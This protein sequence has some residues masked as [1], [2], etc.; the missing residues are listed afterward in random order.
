MAADNHLSSGE[1][2]RRAVAHHQDGE[3][4]QARA[5]YESFLS[6]QPKH[7]GVLHLLGLIA[8]Q[9]G[10]QERAVSLMA[11][12]T[13]I[14]PGNPIF[15]YNL[16]LAL[17]Q[18]RRFEEALKNYDE[19][20]AINPNHAEAHSNRG[21]ALK[22]L[23]RFDE[24][25]ASF[26]VAL[27][28]KPALVEALRNRG[29]THLEMKRLPDAI[30]DFQAALALNPSMPWLFGQYLYAKMMVCDW[31]EFH[32]NRLKLA[33]G[34]AASENITIPFAVLG[35]IDDP[36]LQLAAAAAWTTAEIRK[37]TSRPTFATR[38]TPA[39]IRLG[40]YSADFRAHATSYLMAEML[41]SHDR[42]RFE[43]YA[44][45]FGSQV[46]DLMQRRVASAF[47]QFID[48]DRGGDAE[49]AELSRRL[50][51]DIAI[52]LKG[53][54]AD[55]RPG[56]F[57]ARCAPIQ[58]SFLGYPGTMGAEFIDYIVADRVVLPA[59]AQRY[60]IEKAVYLPGA[61]QPNDS[62]RAVS[63]RALTRSDVGLPEAGFVFCCFNN[64]YKITP[65]A[66]DIWMRVLKAVTGSVLWLLEDNPV[67]AANLRREADIRGISG[68]RLIFAQRLPL[69]EH[70][71]RQK[72]ADLFLDTF[73]CTAH[74]TASD[75]LWAGLPVLTLLGRSFAS[76]VAGSLNLAL[77]LS[78]LVVSSSG[79]YEARAIELASTRELGA[80]RQKLE[81][82]RASAA[83]FSGELFARRIEAAYEIMHR[84]HAASLPPEV[85]EIKQ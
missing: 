44:F 39:K 50:E 75:A 71:A 83:L 9:T 15:H 84:R 47:R 33:A 20:I 4:E 76:R 74:T 73:P 79:A 13:R 55:A 40:Y 51:I 80:L 32:D 11:E 21:A 52:D 72:L 24:A 30:A 25:L 57:A 22:D 5:L 49:V 38:K 65:E 43:L 70:L 34:I 14:Q 85:I 19:V 41:E 7:A 31:S 45:S 1:I 28:L 68:D 26:D 2:L 27:A 69:D 77:D 53:L 67:A 54:T 16:G 29:G 58:V 18:L 46:E 63:D 66:F 35:L 17:H 48:V 37:P 23:R 62:K 42:E 36:A 12:A 81:Q 60:F 56:L 3:F 64:N 82:K 10:E 61:Y 6:R 78:E 8:A 59:D